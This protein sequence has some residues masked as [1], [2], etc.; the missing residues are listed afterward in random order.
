MIS[1]IDKYDMLKWKFYYYFLQKINSSIALT[2][3][4]NFKGIFLSIF[5][6]SGILKDEA[7]SE[8]K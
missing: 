4:R 3:K 5:F 2:L 6:S 7:F 1:K 8:N